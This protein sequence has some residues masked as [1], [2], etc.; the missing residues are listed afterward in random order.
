VRSARSLE[1]FEEEV[2]GQTDFLGRESASRG[3]HHFGGEGAAC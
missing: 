2:G 1:L 3:M